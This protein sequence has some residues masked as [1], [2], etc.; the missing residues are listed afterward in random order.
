MPFRSSMKVSTQFNPRFHHVTYRT[1]PDA[2]GVPPSIAPTVPWTCWRACGRRAGASCPSRRAH[3]RPALALAPGQRV[4]LASLARPG[5]I[6]ALQ[7]RLGAL[8]GPARAE[9]LRGARLQISFDGR[10]TVLAARRV[11]RLG[12]APP[13]CAP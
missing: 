2:A 1:F 6:T 9:L 13:P 8:S 11:L 4:V 10:R 5:A 7:L 3:Y 12:V